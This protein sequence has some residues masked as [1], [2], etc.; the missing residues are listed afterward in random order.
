MSGK[1]FEREYDAILE[2]LHNLKSTTLSDLDYGGLL[3]L[4]SE[5][6]AQEAGVENVA[7]KISVDPLEI[8]IKEVRDGGGELAGEE[9]V[10]WYERAQSE[11]PA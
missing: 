11:M 1:H 6:I 8:S 10:S 5:F 9:N 7:I 4:L 3:R 2:T